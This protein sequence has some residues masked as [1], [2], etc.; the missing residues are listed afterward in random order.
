MNNLY[1][2][3]Q[4][5]SLIIAVIVLTEPAHAYLDPGTGSILL[6]GLIASFALGLAT[7]K[8]WWYRIKSFFSRDKV[9]VEEPSLNTEMEE[10]A[11]EDINLK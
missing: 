1:I 2:V 6:Q 11:K 10:P 5:L 8:L 9:E 3:I 7:I 4:N